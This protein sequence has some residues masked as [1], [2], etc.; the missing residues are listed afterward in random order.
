[1]QGE[2]QRAGSHRPVL[3]R[4]DTHF[5]SRKCNAKEEKKATT[6]KTKLQQSAIIYTEIICLE[7]CRRMWRFP[8]LAF[9]FTAA[10]RSRRKKTSCVSRPECFT[11]DRRQQTAKHV[12]Q[13]SLASHGGAPPLWHHESFMVPD[14]HAR[15]P[16]ERNTRKASELLLQPNLV[17]LI[18]VFL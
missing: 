11:F 17:L 12:E 10:I 4:F 8:A 9:K 3:R 7:L 13:S 1:M 5:P 14:L 18:S 16:L 6:K 15:L 2:G